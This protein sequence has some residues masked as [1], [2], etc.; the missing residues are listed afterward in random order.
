M[1]GKYVRGETARL[2][3]LIDNLWHLPPTLNGIG[4][5]GQ[6]IWGSIK[7]HLNKSPAGHLQH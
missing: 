2:K 7:L 6:A 3:I 1:G 4:M 5:H